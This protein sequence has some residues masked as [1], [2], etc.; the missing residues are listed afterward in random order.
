MRNYVVS[1][2]GVGGSS[3]QTWGL[4][5]ILMERNKLGNFDKSFCEG[6]CIKIR[7]IP[8]VKENSVTEKCFRNYYI[9]ILF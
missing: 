9:D 5:T 7:N 2:R 6:N 3:S 8:K 4:M 1:K